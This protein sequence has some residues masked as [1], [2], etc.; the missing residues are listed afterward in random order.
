M[1]KLLQAIDIEKCIPFFK[2]GIASLIICSMLMIDV[3]KAMP[4]EDD[5]LLVH[6]PLPLKPLYTD[7]KVIIDFDDFSTRQNSSL[8]EADSST[9]SISTSPEKS[10]AEGDKSLAVIL[11]PVLSSAFSQ[12]TDASPSQPLDVIKS[13]P[14]PLLVR[15][16]PKVV[17]VEEHSPQVQLSSSMGTSPL[18]GS[19]QDR[20]PQRLS[21]QSIAD[22]SPNNGKPVAPIP[23][24]ILS[25]ENYDPLGGSSSETDSA[26]D[27][28]ISFPGTQNIPRSPSIPIKKKKRNFSSAPVFSERRLSDENSKL[29]DPTLSLKY[30]SIQTEDGRDDPSPSIEHLG[31]PEDHSLPVIEDNSKC[32]SCCSNR[33]LWPQPTEYTFP[34]ALDEIRRRSEFFLA[35]IPNH[36]T[37]SVSSSHD[38]S[39]SFSL[40][41]SDSSSPHGSPPKTLGVGGILL[42]SDEDDPDITFDNSAHS[43]IY[44]ANTDYESLIDLQSPAGI[45]AGTSLSLIH[46]SLLP[47][48][49]LE[50][51]E[52]ILS[53]LSAQTTFKQLLNDLK[54]LPPAAKSQLKDFVH[55]VLNGKSTWPQRLGK[56]I[57]G[58]IIG[59]GF[60]WAMGPVYDGGVD[61]LSNQSEAFNQFLNGSAGGIFILYIQISAVPDGLSRNA[62][63]WKKGIA[64]LAQEGKEKGRMCLAGFISTLTACI[65]L[66]YLI[67]A[68]NIGRQLSGFTNWYN[69][70]GVIIAMFGPPLY[71]DALASDFNIA[72]NAFPQMKEWLGRLWC[73]KSLQAHLPVHQDSPGERFDSSLKSLEH[74]LFRAPKAVIDEIYDNVTQIREGTQVRCC[75]NYDEALASQQA[76]AVLS[77]VL[78]LGDDVIKGASKPKS[79]YDISTEVFNHA[80]LILGTPARALALQFIGYSVFSLFCPDP[81]AQILGGIYMIFALLPQTY[82][83]DRGMDNFFKRFIFE[84]DP[85]GHGA[86]P[87]YRGLTKLYCVLQGLLYTFPLTILTLQAC[88]QWFGGG[89]WPLAAGI[90]FFIP[91]FAAQTYS[92]NGTFNQLVTT[93]SINGGHKV[94]GKCKGD[95]LCSS[96]KK[97]WLVRF[98][99]EGR[100]NLPHWNNEFVDKLSEGVKIFKGQD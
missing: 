38:S 43:A 99:Q 37:E 1:K 7:Q 83:E 50:R 64:Y 81:I 93:S 77:Y 26:E 65:P 34:N 25:P 76:F 90:P 63:L 10:T 88:Q 9:G 42:P 3:A 16:G 68:E 59:A 22:S 97:D 70:F 86:H 82:L 84:E 19:L 41:E 47:A 87:V 53:S 74:F 15:S 55:Q 52:L 28:P 100:E 58:P 66:A 17:I 4:G 69:G 75:E 5:P 45:P 29:L 27:M 6:N 85:H 2:K 61:Y 35:P 67:S 39:D 80:C 56:W 62:H 30:S 51:G 54:K 92:F 89:W 18:A 96:C 49:D 14:S 31:D 95:S 33:P 57:I 8:D 20:S 79:I 73:R 71:A 11:L 78:S 60:A 13:Q 23:D 21:S 24:F 32:C 36:R 91:E 72:W 40:G 98:V 48:H 12:S 46:H 94:G 44:P